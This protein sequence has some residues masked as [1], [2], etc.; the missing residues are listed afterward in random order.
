M[1]LVRQ[2]GD[3]D[4]A[5]AVLAMVQGIRYADAFS[6]LRPIGERGV[7]VAK[8][9]RAMGGKIVQTKRTRAD[10]LARVSECAALLRERG[11]RVGHWV[12]WNGRAILC[13]ERGICGIDQFS[14]YLMAGYILK[15][16]RV[17]K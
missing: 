9:A 15:K 12:A 1:R 10:A 16:E 8:L 3:Y 17:E 13:P 7:S 6:Q 2:R 14:G 5:V 11:G 4:C